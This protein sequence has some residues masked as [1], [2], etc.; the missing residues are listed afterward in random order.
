MQESLTDHIGHEQ[1]AAAIRLDAVNAT[2]SVVGQLRA[3]LRFQIERKQMTAR[4]RA[5]SAARA[6]ARLR[7]RADAAQNQTRAVDEKTVRL[8]DDI[9][10]FDEYRGLAVLDRVDA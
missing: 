1:S 4:R 10:A 3:L 5:A 6:C 2:N 9:T 8:L 7:C